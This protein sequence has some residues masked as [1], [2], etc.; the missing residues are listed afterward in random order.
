[1]APTRPRSSYPTRCRNHQWQKSET[2]LIVTKKG[3]EQKLI[4]NKIKLDYL[5]PPIAP[6]PAQHKCLVFCTNKHIQTHPQFV[7]IRLDCFHHRYLAEIAPKVE[8]KSVRESPS[9][10]PT[11]YVHPVAVG[12]R[13]VRSIVKYLFLGALGPGRTLRLGVVDSMRLTYRKTL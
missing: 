1:M 7:A 12:F 10:T 8:V 2:S 3:L 6:S 9:W 11:R 13:G 4:Q 5:S